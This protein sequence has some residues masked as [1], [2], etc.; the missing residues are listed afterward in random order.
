MPFDFQ[1]IADIYTKVNNFFSADS[2]N[3]SVHEPLEIAIGCIGSS[4]SYEHFFFRALE[5][6]VPIKKKATTLDTAL[7]NSSYNVDV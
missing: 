5:K 1:C 6:A 2:K 4:L 3:I 7:A